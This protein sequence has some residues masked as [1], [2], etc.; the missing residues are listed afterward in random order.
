MGKLSLLLF[1]YPCLL[2]A[3][4]PENFFQ[5]D[6]LLIEKI[7]HKEILQNIN[8]N[9]FEPKD[10]F[11]YY[12]TDP[13][14]IVPDEFGVSPY[15]FPIV[16]F[17]FNIYTIY[18]S[19]HAVIHDKK[20]LKIIYEVID[21]TE[22]GKS[23][24]NK[25]TKH[26]IQ[27][28]LSLARIKK[29]KSL[30][31]E[32]GRKKKLSR[33][34]KELLKQIVKTGVSIPKSKKRRKSFFKKLSKNLRTQTGQ[35]HHI[36][37]GLVNIIPFQLFLNQAVD[38]YKLPRSLLAMPFLE[39]S[40]NIRAR[41][42]VGATGIWQFM[43]R[44][45]R[46]FMVVNKSTDHRLNPV[47]STLGALHLLRQNKQ[48][49]KRWDLA[50]SAYNSGTKHIVRA[51]RKLKNRNISLEQIFK[52]YKHPHFGFASQNF[53]ASYLAL[54]HALAYRGQFYTKDS[55]TKYK[56]LQVNPKGLSLYVTKCSFTP[57]WFFNK[58]KKSS[59]DIHYLNTHL[60]NKK[61]VYP[62]GTLLVSDIKLN[63]KKYYRVK[64]SQYTKRYP[65]NMYKFIRKQKCNL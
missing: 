42:K 2:F 23:T 31:L 11:T 32:L 20:D 30:L 9:S 49:V 60:K 57:G 45:G 1:F 13:K 24:L 14:S 17:W 61:Q 22:L 8:V 19:H 16:R 35:K 6:Y 7:L 3:L 21:F 25:H 58:L 62:R 4:V 47:I 37:Q 36:E 40:F 65:K 15:F 44:I 27:N 59:P 52:Q 48:V 18:G 12:S 38:R 26:S 50:I 43:R 41:S 53:Y 54:V 33:E 34:A 10:K 63:S 5:D 28:R 64:A 55:V 29:I 56:A 39:S 51:R 46:A